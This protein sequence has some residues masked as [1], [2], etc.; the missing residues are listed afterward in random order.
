MVQYWG[1]IL[2][3]LGFKA[4]FT[5]KVLV[6]DNLHLNDKRQALSG[7]CA[8]NMRLVSIL[9]TCV[10]GG[11]LI[12]V[13]TWALS[14]VAAVEMGASVVIIT[15]TRTPAHN[16]TY[17]RIRHSITVLARPRHR[18]P[19]LFKFGQFECVMRAK[20]RGCC[21]RGNACITGH[22]YSLRNSD[23]PKYRKS[24]TPN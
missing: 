4:V 3:L 23:P 15:I 16:L 22:L 8:D 18:A 17:N 10:R 11:L 6:W 7:V 9:V 12:A 2:N 5:P 21:C 19:E 20:A 24:I 13:S 14:R 1:A